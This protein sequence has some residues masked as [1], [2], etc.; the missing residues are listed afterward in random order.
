MPRIFRLD[1]PQN[2]EELSHRLE[3]A[4]SSP[5]LLEGLYSLCRQLADEPDKYD[6]LI[7]DD[8]SGRLVTLVLRRIL[9]NRREKSGLPPM[10]V[11]F[12]ASGRNEPL[13]QKAIDHFV[14]R[15]ASE[16]GRVLIVTELVDTGDSLR[17]LTKSFAKKKLLPGIAALSVAEHPTFYAKKFTNNLIFGVQGYAGVDL[18]DE[19]T[20]AGVRKD[21]TQRGAHPRRYKDFDLPSLREANQE[22]V[23]QA[24]QEVKLIADT[25]LQ[26]LDKG[27]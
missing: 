19:H 26:W 25:F 10:K 13:Q 5:R 2:P 4:I 24:R 27:Y 22:K 23:N 20:F 6:T 7:S 12:L 21:N 18:H 14:A 8:A 15:H 17:D 11:W 3:T 16:L 1:G 9:D